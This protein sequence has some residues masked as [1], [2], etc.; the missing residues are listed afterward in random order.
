MSEVETA[1][2][3]SLLDKLT[4]DM[5]KKPIV[6]VSKTRKEILE[7][8]FEK[9]TS[10]QKEAFLNELENRKAKLN[11]KRANSKKRAKMAKAARKRN[12][13]N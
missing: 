3:K 2:S 10:S 8:R 11:K 7:E 5:E 9:L 6:K 12:R 13:M 4:A 1:S